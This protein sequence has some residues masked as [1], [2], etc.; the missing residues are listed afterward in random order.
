ME[1]L[2]DGLCLSLFS[3]RPRTLSPFSFSCSF[4]VPG[5]VKPMIVIVSH[6][7]LS[8][9]GKPK[10][11]LLDF[12]YKDFWRNLLRGDQV[13]NWGSWVRLLSFQIPLPVHVLG[14][15]SQTQPLCLSSERPGEYCSCPS[16]IGH[17]EKKAV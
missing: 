10:A 5:W 6:L 13:Y 4:F 12:F 8:A 17:D 2:L 14:S 1:R 7:I 3:P 11:W 16:L 9:L 15:I